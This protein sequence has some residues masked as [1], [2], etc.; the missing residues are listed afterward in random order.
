MEYRE[1][2]QEAISKLG[3]EVTEQEKKLAEEALVKIYEEEMPP[4]DAIGFTK[5]MMEGLY[6]FAYRLYMTGKFK[7]AAVMFFFLVRLDP[8]DPRLS[9][10]LGATNHMLKE[11][12]KAIDGYMLSIS[13]QPG[14]PIPYYHMCD[15]FLHL[16]DTW[17][18]IFCLRA[19]INTCAKDP[20]FAK[21][22]ER[23]RLMLAQLEEQMA[24]K[25]N[26]VSPEAQK[27]AG[28]TQGE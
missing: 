23:S 9:F 14:Y 5:G 6:A 18:A 24:Q 21:I 8:T 17:C 1:A 11:Y 12:R 28:A 25:Q 27:I 4:K 16:N 2:I 15:C 26:E 22:K 20:L 7:E 3:P 10:G 19:V 13:Q